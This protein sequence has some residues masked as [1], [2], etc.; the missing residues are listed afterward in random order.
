MIMTT[1]IRNAAPGDAA[2]ML[3]IYSHYVENT[4][5]SFEYETPSL[6][7]FLGRI[8]AVQRRFPWLVLEC[9]GTI[10]GYAYAAP[11]HPRA[12]YG[13]CCETTIY[14]DHKARRKGFGRL[15]YS[16][17]EAALR[18][19]G[20][21]NL[22]A[23]VAWPERPDPCLTTDSALFH[24]RMGYRRAGC[25]RLCGYK[26]GRWYDMLYFEKVI[27]GHETPVDPVVPFDGS[28]P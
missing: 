1:I 12:A 18:R 6:E 21:Q 3:E 23:L 16:T 10:M 14:L 8:E 28:I 13:W 11:A 7:T 9:S 22:Y 19:M 4:A 2:R 20:I 17:L 26:F 24:E 27:G 25:Q 5:V 15:L